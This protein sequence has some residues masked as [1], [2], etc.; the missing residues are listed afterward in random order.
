MKQK[1]KRFFTITMAA[2]AVSAG[3]VASELTA[4]RGT[5]TDG[6]NFW[7]YN[8]DDVESAEPKPV[9]IFL[10]GASLCGNDLNRVKR[11][12][13]I[14]AI[15]KGRELDAFVI[16]PQNPGGA[17]S[18]KKVM[19]VL[20]WV[21]DNYNIDYDRVYV[22]G[23]S[24][25]GYGTIDVAATY[26]DRIAAAIAMCGGG[27]V[28]DLSGLNQVPLWIIHGTAD[29]AV[30]ISQSDK[31][32]AA[33]KA[34]ANG[35]TPRLVYNRIPGMNH[36]QPARMFYL[37]ESYEWLLS[38]TLKDHTRAVKP[39]FAV[40]EL[41]ANAYRDLRHGTSRKSRSVATARTPSKHGAKTKTTPRRKRRS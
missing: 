28:R 27:S 30:S 24:L 41:M 13:T 35:E 14:D 16:A 19:N 40:T 29:A 36:S 20:D 21:S 18:P 15:E 1:L 4:H 37:S 23:M 5:V 38:H 39:G 8:P 12:G 7:L 22:L 17:W 25:G 10:H 11:Y 6:Y 33:M 26:P 9:F 32:V 34:A 2:L 3:A 31:V